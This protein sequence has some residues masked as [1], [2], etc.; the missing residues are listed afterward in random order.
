MSP[1]SVHALPLPA[2]LLSFLQKHNGTALAVPCEKLP[3]SG[4]R[5]LG[6]K[7]VK[8]SVKQSIT[9]GC[10]A[11]A[12]DSALSHFLFQVSMG[13]G[14]PI[15]DILHH[16]LQFHNMMLVVQPASSF[17][18]LAVSAARSSMKCVN[19]FLKGIY[20]LLSPYHSTDIAFPFALNF[21]YFPLAVTVTI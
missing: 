8:D 21:V 19:K 12:M 1:G 17:T 18:Q 16:G 15:N 6:R 3:S 5:E 2:K 11:R 4:A 7:V 13:T 10:S 9:A 20:L 14:E